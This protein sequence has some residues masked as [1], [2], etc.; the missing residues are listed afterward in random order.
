M[1]AGT[2]S[3]IA[4]HTGTRLEY[5]ETIFTFHFSAGLV[6]NQPNHG[7]VLDVEDRA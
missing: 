3:T 7:P 1:A 4:E 2:T 5:P 6:G